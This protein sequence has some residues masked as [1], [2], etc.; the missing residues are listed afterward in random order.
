MDPAL[1]LSPGKDIK[2]NP[3]FPILSLK[4]DFFKVLPY[5]QG[6]ILAKGM[7]GYIVLAACRDKPDI[8]RAVKV[9]PLN[10]DHNEDAAKRLFIREINTFHV[11]N[12]SGLAKC[13]L[14][15]RCPDYLAI[16]MKFYPLGDLKRNLSS[17]PP[18]SRPWIAAR[19]SDAL[20]YL[21]GKRIVH[22]DI[23]LEN[24]LLDVGFAPVL[25]DFGLSRHL[26]EDVLTLSANKFGGT[27][28]Y[29]PP[30]IRDRDA[31]LQ[32]DPFKVTF[33]MNA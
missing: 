6:P 16:V 27:R 24:I 3:A 31:H 21:H 30:E 17:L 18:V 11:T 33:F 22:G 4:G 32:V 23:K 14:A 9:L 29:W 1:V 28:E 12:H 25:A 13:I 8:L 10:A 26:A 19:L 2:R 20:A 7:C 15:A 5:S